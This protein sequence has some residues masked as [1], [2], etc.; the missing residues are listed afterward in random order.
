MGNGRGGGGP[1]PLR[2]APA[3]VSADLHTGD[4]LKGGARDGEDE[5]GDGQGKPIGGVEGAGAGAGGEYRRMR[6]RPVSYTH[7]T[8]PTI[9][10]V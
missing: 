5:S 6:G 4:F 3:A 8:L 10:R 2:G 1:S 9:L 7:L